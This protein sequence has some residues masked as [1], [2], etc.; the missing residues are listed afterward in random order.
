MLTRAPV[1]LFENDDV[2]LADKPAGVLTTGE[3]D[4]K[5]TF[6]A[7]LQ[8]ESGKNMKALHRLDRDTSGVVAFARNEP[9]R[10]L[11]EPLF[12]KHETE[13]VYLALLLGTFPSDKGTLKNYLRTNPKTF[14]EEVV[15][16]PKFGIEARLSYKVLQSGKGVSLVEIRPETGRTNQIRVQFAHD[17]H[18]VLGDR[19]YSKGKIFPVPARRT[20]LHAR[21][22]AFT[23][24]DSIGG[25]KR[26][27]AKSPL[28]DDFREAIA[29]AALSMKGLG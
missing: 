12:R 9:A 27:Q 17:T 18:P 26:I 25:G 6:E 11:L 21:S 29:E 20:L 13:R 28:P 4:D 16:N 8:A 14:T 10:K 23:P 24:P 19:K 3:K 5:N 2:I 22:L 7:K 15:Y 1:I